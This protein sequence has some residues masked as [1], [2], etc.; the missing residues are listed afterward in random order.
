M[1]SVTAAEP[2]VDNP[3]P[4]PY[5]LHPTPCTLHPTPCTLHPTPYTAS[6]L[7]NQRS[8]T[9]VPGWYL[10]GRTLQR[11]R[12]VPA[13][14]MWGGGRRQRRMSGE[15]GRGERWRRGASPL[16]S[17]RFLSLTRKVDVRLPGEA[18]QRSKPPVPTTLTVGT[19]RDEH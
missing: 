2:E 9:P 10:P 19:Y 16:P 12:L 17:Q 18:S 8:T 1:E 11:C 14:R 15:P 5:T 3:H 6:P 13:P 4:T 7:P